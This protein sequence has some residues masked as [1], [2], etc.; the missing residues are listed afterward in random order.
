MLLNLAYVRES[1]WT[2][3]DQTSAYA[4]ASQDQLDA[5]TSRINQ[6]S[7]R[8]LQSGKWKNSLRRFTVDIHDGYVT[9]PREVESM[10]G[11]KLMTSTGLCCH[12][13]IYSRF[14]EFSHATCCCDHAV[15]A[16]SETA[17]TF[18]V[19][20]SPFTLRIKSTVASGT[21][22]FIGGWDEDGNE[23]FGADTVN[24]PNG[25]ADG[26]RTYGSLPPTGGIQK[27]ATTVPVELYSVD[28]DGNETLIA[29]YAPYETIPSY[30]KYQVPDCAQYTQALIWGKLAYVPASA[31]T[32]IVIPSN[33]GAL[34]MALKALQDE[35]TDEDQHALQNWAT[36][37]NILD[38]EVTEAD[39]D[40]EFPM[41][42][43]QYE[44]GC[45]GIP[46]LI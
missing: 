6:A 35:D 21:V 44:F 26:T 16:V 8:I 4:T 28:S 10:V 18:L 24:I 46:N 41:F 39:N 43:T 2:Y 37:F 30:R 25:S 15:R 27:S 1:L 40:A 45:E 42:R 14:H 20:D 22:S 31:D 17:Q 36:C 32:D 3:A 5:A 38:Q 13:V 9:M 29:V 33:L 23:F 11:I 7:E 34:K 19:P 12:S